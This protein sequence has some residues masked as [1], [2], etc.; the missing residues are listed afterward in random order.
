V[1]SNQSGD[2][3]GLLQWVDRKKN[4]RCGIIF[5]HTEII[6]GQRA[7]VESNRDYWGYSFFWHVETY[8][9]VFIGRMRNL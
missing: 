9:F 5:V 2:S 7:M 6:S 4:D 3:D 8:H 1:C